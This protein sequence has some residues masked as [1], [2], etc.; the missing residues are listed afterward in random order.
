MDYSTAGV[1]RGILAEKGRLTSHEWLAMR[2][3]DPRSH[4]ARYSVFVVSLDGHKHMAI[5][6]VEW[7][8]DEGA[9]NLGRKTG[10][11]AKI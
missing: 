4:S 7:K 2:S 8:V 10:F 5:S 3:P 11:V 9:D 1:D 6:K